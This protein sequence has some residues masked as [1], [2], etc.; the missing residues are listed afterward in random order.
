MVVPLIMKIEKNFKSGK[1]LKSAQFC[2]FYRALRKASVLK[3]AA[4]ASE[5][6]DFLNTFLRF[7]GF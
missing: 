6:G 2:Y 1:M 3:I 4:K 7:W 5:A